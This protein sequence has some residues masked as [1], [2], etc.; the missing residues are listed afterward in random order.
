MITL[1]VSVGT[2]RFKSYTQLTGAKTD[3]LGNNEKYKLITFLFLQV[4]DKHAS[5][6]LETI[7]LFGRTCGASIIRFN[8][9]Q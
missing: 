8:I 3:H 9:L 4:L 6:S 7:S 2:R 1:S 5:Q